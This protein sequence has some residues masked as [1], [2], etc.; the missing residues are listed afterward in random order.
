MM[1]P[2]PRPASAPKKTEI[3]TGREEGFVHNGEL[4][5]IP[6]DQIVATLKKDDN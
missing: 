5:Q 1:T 3:L 2:P 4:T 6:L